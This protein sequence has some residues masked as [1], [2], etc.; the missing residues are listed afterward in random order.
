M[1]ATSS[2]APLE[3]TVIVAAIFWTWLWGAVGLLLAVPLTVC[4]IVVGRHIPQFAF[5]SIMLGDQPV[6]SLQDRIYQRLLARDQEEAAELAEEYVGKNGLESL[7]E[8]VLIPVLDLAKRDRHRDAL[9]EERTRFVFDSTRTLVEDL[10]EP[11]VEGKE[12]AAS[13]EAK[14]AQEPE[15]LAG[16][17]T[18]CIV[19]AHDE[20]DEIVGSMLRRCLTRRNVVS[21]LLTT[22][23]LKGEVLDRVTELAPQVLYISA[24]P[25]AAVLH[26]SYFCKRLRPRF[27]QLKI[28]VAVWHAE[29]DMEKG[30]SRLLA[31]GASEVVITLKHAIE[32]LPPAALVTAMQSAE[33]QADLAAAA[34]RTSSAP[35]AT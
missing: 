1:P 25:P 8:N 21:E 9:S 11:A 3:C 35:S 7:Y 30:S 32:K 29:G 19:P 4:L 20:A 23:V 18:A 24:L 26:A 14:D 2:D 6:L 31:A 22:H 34:N 28:V 10:S 13:A 17:V 16:P 15:T 12:S 27:P 5:L 33:A